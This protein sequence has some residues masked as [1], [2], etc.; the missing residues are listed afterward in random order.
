MSKHRPPRAPPPASGVTSASTLAEILRAN[1]RTRLEIIGR[2][3][4]AELRALEAELADMPPVPPR[5]TPPANE[6]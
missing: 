1:I 6:G 2:Q 4:F 3:A 5:E